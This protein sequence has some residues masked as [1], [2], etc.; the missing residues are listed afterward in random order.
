M[1]VRGSIYVLGRVGP[2]DIA[3]DEALE[4]IRESLDGPGEHLIPIR[5]NGELVMG[6]LERMEPVN[7]TPTT[8]GLELIVEI[9]EDAIP[10]HATESLEKASAMAEAILEQKRD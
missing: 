9:D 7:T 6:R 3:T 4:R 10:S 8:R 1:K 2:F 5:M